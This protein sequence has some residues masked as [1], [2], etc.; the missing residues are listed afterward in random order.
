QHLPLRSFFTF[1]L[2]STQRQPSNNVQVQ[3]L[4]L[5]RRVHGPSPVMKRKRR[6]KLV[7]E[8][9]VGSPSTWSNNVC[10]FGEGEAV[11][12]LSEGTH[13]QRGEANA[14]CTCEEREL[15]DTVVTDSVVGW[16]ER[17]CTVIHCRITFQQPWQLMV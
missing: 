1:L 13:G 16:K 7:E 2:V 12:E 15:Q 9:T 17:C 11:V 8:F 14:A 3:Q 5:K 4:S 6:W 10:V